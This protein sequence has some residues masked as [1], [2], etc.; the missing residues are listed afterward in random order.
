MKPKILLILGPT[1]SGKS[2]LAVTL[3]RKLG[4][5][6]VSADSRQVY[7]GLDIGTG[8]I[9]RREMKGVPHHLLDVA[10]PKRQFTVA[11]YKKLADKAIDDIL[12]RGKLPIIC[13]GTGFYIQAIVDGTVLPEVAPNARLR[14]VLEKKSALE[15]FKILKKLD[16]RRAKEIDKNNPRRL[17]RAIEIAKA[18]GKNPKNESKP[19]YDAVQIG[20]KLSDAELKKRITIRLFDRIR[21]YMISEARQLHKKGLSWKRMEALGL[22]Y[23][24]LA[25][26]LKGEISREEMISKLK[27]EIWHYAKRQMT[28]F[29]RDKRIQWISL[30]EM[31]TLSSLR[32]K[33]RSK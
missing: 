22:E 27:T 20:I 13:G 18:L 32:G 30:K 5:E 12:A 7:K 24:Y 3:A 15:L 16:S 17:I 26:F 33:L 4:G 14:A 8:K 31:A 9:T 29:K 6:I 21:K 10:S 25:K 19:K 2:A 1:A 11:E 23:R 28:W